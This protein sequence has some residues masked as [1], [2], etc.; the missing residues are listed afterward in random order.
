MYTTTTEHKGVQLAGC[1]LYAC[2]KYTME[3]VGLQERNT[4]A[5]DDLVSL[6][7]SWRARKMSNEMLTLAYESVD[8]QKAERLRSCATR[9]T[10]SVMPDGSRRLA[11]ANFCRVRLCPICQWRRSL[12][13]FAQLS[14]VLRLFDRMGEKWSYVLVTLTVPS[15][16][17]DGLAAAID[18]LQHAWDKFSRRKPV[19][20][21]FKGYFK[22][23]EITHNIDRYSPNYDT[24]HPHFHVMFA[25]RP[26]YFKSRYYLSRDAI[27]ELW[28]QSLRSDRED[29]QVDVR[30]IWGDES[31]SSDT[32]AAALEVSK[33]AVK[34]TDYIVPDDWELT[35]DAVRILDDA[36]D[37]RRFLS[38][39]GI[40]ADA[41]VRLNQDDA[42]GGDLVR[43]TGEK[44]TDEFPVEVYG[45]SYG[46]KEYCQVEH[47]SDMVL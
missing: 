18:H 14:D 29:L 25:V 12:K 47:T 8:V 23:L 44:E 42:D 2:H 24:Y 38:W 9:L 35:E 37:N 28:R 11:S 3:T 26:S 7:R 39:G 32:I 22:S 40:F 46:Y 21:A 36:L 33:Y 30:K 45:W 1:I 15:V 17:G 41:R 31:K 4:I 10:F 27:R 5:A 43:L 34:T 13:T 6:S 20:M 16:E 19:K